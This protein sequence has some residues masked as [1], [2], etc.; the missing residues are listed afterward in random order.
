MSEVSRPSG[1]PM[2][3]NQQLRTGSEQ[4][5]IRA[6][7]NVSVR[8]SMKQAMASSAWKLCRAARTRVTGGARQLCRLTWPGSCEGRRAYLPEWVPI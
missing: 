6:S 8:P 5:V 1:C 7:L 2:S 3:T 4:K